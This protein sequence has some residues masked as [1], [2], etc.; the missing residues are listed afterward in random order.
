MMKMRFVR[1]FMTALLTVFSLLGFTQE[2]TDGQILKKIEFVLCPD[3][4]KI[5]KAA[6]AEDI[7]EV[8]V[9][10]FTEAYAYMTKMCVQQE[11]VTEKKAG[12]FYYTYTLPDGKGKLVLTDKVTAG[13]KEVAVLQVEIESLKGRVSEVRFVKK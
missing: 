8:V 4:K 9:K 3:G 6:G 13:T 5:G 11:V 12:N 1:S 10:D 7:R 2:K